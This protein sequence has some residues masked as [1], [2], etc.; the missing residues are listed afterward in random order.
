MSY[1]RLESGY[2]NAKGL[3]RFEREA[4]IV[5]DVDYKRGILSYFKSD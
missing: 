2:Q 1:K 4:I 5:K 3:T